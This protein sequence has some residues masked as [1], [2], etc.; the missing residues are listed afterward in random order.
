MR[1][2]NK[3]LLGLLLVTIFLFTGLFATVR[4]KYA[5]GSI[6]KDY[7]EEVEQKKVD[8]PIN[9]PV[10][11]VSLSMLSDVTITTSDSLKLK[12]W[13]NENGR[14]K[15][16]LQD[17][18]LSIGIDTAGIRPGDR[19]EQARQRIE[20]FLPAVDSIYAFNT[21]ININSVMDSGKVGPSFN[22]QLAVSSLNINKVNFDHESPSVYG[23]LNIAAGPQ[24][25]VRFNTGVHIDEANL[26]LSGAN[27]E[28]DCTFNKLRIQ[29]DSTTTL[30]IKGANLR[31]ATIT[32]TE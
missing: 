32:S 25:E 20:L 10:K 13:D 14:V 30:K 18:V 31:K 28:E 5:N 12:I 26:R 23:K 29:T 7:Q 24:S 11:M 6:V 4:I 8:Q 19:L 2:S 9:G 27:F 1:T 17:G 21:G 3:I 16:H 22:F 15:Y